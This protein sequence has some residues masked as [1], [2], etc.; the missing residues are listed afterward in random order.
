M[1]LWDSESSDYLDSGPDQYG[2]QTDW[3]AE[4]GPR[5]FGM[6]DYWKRGKRGGF[7]GSGGRK[8]LNKSGMFELEGGDLEKWQAMREDGARGK[9]EVGRKSGRAE[10]LGNYGLGHLYDAKEGKGF[11]GNMPRNNNPYGQ[12]GGGYGGMG[13]MPNLGAGIQQRISDMAKRKKDNKERGSRMSW[14]EGETKERAGTRK[15]VLNNKEA[16]KDAYK[17]GRDDLS[18]GWGN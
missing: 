5:K 10:G 16:M 18:S 13:G 2:I 14:W 1:A 17:K 9:F 3:G 12:Y 6:Q 11:K 8:K 4:G 15:A 7:M